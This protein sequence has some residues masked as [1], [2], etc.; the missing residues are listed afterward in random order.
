MQLQC[1]YID[2]SEGKG[3]GVFT[4]AFIAKGTLIE[5]APVIVLPERDKPLIDQTFLYNYYFLWNDSPQTY[6]IALG[7]VSL[8]NHS[9]PANCEYLTFYEDEVIQIVT[10]R[11][12]QPGEELTVNYNGEANNDTPVW[13]EK[14]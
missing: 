13:F 14:T 2:S 10:L 3:R 12:I 9:V 5:I 6:A 4:N 1:L 11:D 8:Y 7:N